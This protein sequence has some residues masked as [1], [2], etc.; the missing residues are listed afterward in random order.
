METQCEIIDIGEMN[1]FLEMDIYQCDARIFITERKRKY[2]LKILK[3]FRK[4]NYKPVNTR[5]YHLMMLVVK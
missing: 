5:S 2:A 4:Q 1:Y 3:K